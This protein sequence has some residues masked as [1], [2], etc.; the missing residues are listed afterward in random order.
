MAETNTSASQIGNSKGF[1]F[2]EPMAFI[3]QEINIAASGGSNKV[4]MQI[5]GN[6]DFLV[7]NITGTVYDDKGLLVGG[8]VQRTH[9]LFTVQMK[10]EAGSHFYA[11]QAFD[12]VMLNRLAEANSWMQVVIRRGTKLILEVAHVLKGTDAGN[13]SEAAPYNVQLLFHGAYVVPRDNS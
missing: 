12:L 11:N 2:V 8:S 4:T 9:N 6:Q 13:I 3:S 1:A 7:R 10:H 5:R